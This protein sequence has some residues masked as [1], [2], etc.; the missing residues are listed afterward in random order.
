[1][2]LYRQASDAAAGDVKLEAITQPL[3]DNAN[4]ASGAGITALFQNPAGRSPLFTNVESAGSLTW[5]KRFNVKAFRLIPSP[6]GDA[7][8][9]VSLHVNGHFSFRVGEKIYFICPNFLLTPGVG[10]EVYQILGAA[11]P[12]APANSVN[13]AH[14]GRPDHHNLYVVQH[15]I[16]LPSVQNFRVTL[17]MAATHV[18]GVAISTWVMLEGEYFREIQ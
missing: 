4:I 15:P 14:N 10:F 3:Y 11:V 16:W 2:P 9:V 18:P 13:L 6:S 17:D 12:A 5:P 8:A 1:M 7:E